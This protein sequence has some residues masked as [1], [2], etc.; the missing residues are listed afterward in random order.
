MNHHESFCSTSPQAEPNSIV[1]R[2]R[3]WWRPQDTE[4]QYLAAAAD[5]ADLERR[6]R[7]LERGRPG[8]VFVTTYNH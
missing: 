2:L 8:P 4:Q 3:R 1:Q 7:V 5:L 6:M